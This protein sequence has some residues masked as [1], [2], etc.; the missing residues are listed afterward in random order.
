MSMSHEPNSIFTSA[1]GSDWLY[2]TGLHWN[3][4]GPDIQVH[5]KQQ[6]L[7][8]GTLT[9]QIKAPVLSFGRFQKGRHPAIFTTIYQKQSTAWL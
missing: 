8:Q 4:G 7:V 3:H 6:G 1:S 9:C 5:P 2:W